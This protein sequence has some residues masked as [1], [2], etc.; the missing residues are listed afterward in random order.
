MNEEQNRRQGNGL[1]GEYVPCKSEDLFGVL[2]PTEKLGKQ[3]T[4][5]TALEEQS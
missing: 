4:P 5:N 3:C 1:V 2:V